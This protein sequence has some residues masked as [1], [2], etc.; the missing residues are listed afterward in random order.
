MTA[1]LLRRLATA[2]VV[3]SASASLASAQTLLGDLTAN[4]AGGSI[5]D[6][7]TTTSTITLA[8]PGMVLGTGNN[9]TVRIN[10]LSHTYFNDLIATLTYTNGSTSISAR[11]F[12]NNGGSGDPN[13]TYSFNSGFL[14]NVGSIGYAGGDYAPVDNFSVFNGVSV[15]GNWTLAIYDDAGADVGGFQSWDIGLA[16]TAA[17]TVP[18]PSTY[19]LMGSGLLGLAGVARRRRKA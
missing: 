3:L 18:E 10:G 7:N 15:A 14:G 1:S 5:S 8:S 13:G 17:S 6:G 2:A 12:D 4:G 16:T 11:L 19:V 9:V